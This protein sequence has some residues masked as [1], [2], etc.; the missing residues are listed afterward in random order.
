MFSNVHDLCLEPTFAKFHNDS[1]SML[2]EKL[3]DKVTVNN[4]ETPTLIENQNSDQT[5]EQ[6]TCESMFFPI[7]LLALSARM[8][9]HST[10][11]EQHVWKEDRNDLTFLK[12]VLLVT[13][14]PC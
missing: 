4:F 8:S 6:K 5:K 14:F 7:A 2:L 3:K 1:A 11:A 10:F 12:Y 13:C 9:N